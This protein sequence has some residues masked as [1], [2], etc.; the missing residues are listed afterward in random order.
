MFQFASILKY[1][2]CPNLFQCKNTWVAARHGCK[3]CIKNEV[4]PINEHIA[5]PDIYK[6][7]RIFISIQNLSHYCYSYLP[8]F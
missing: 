7:L 8:K 1:R 2:F 6:K 5:Y 4:N 3:I